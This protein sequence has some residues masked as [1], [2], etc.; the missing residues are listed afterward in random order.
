M[1]TFTLFV[2]VASVTSWLCVGAM[3]LYVLRQAASRQHKL[4][5]SKNSVRSFN[6]NVDENTA[7]ATCADADRCIC[8]RY[9]LRSN[10]WP[11]DSLPW[12]LCVLS[13][14][15]QGKTILSLYAEE[16]LHK[17]NTY[18]HRTYLASYLCVV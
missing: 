4:L 6:Y 12:Y 15:V 13:S 2:V 3:V 14:F 9:A 5:W 1:H 7:A 10:I 17:R 16:C 11:S 8:E 18:L